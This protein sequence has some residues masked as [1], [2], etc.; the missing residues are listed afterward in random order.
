MLSVLIPWCI[1][2]AKPRRMGCMALRAARLRK[3]L[4]RLSARRL[5]AIP[6]RSRYEDDGQ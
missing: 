1:G 2:V 6:I 5:E 3:A 4:F